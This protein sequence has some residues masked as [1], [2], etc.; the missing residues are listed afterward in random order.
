MMSVEVVGQAIRE[1]MIKYEEQKDVWV[2]KMGE[3]FNE[4][5]FHAWFTKQVL[6]HATVPNGTV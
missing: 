5:E 4:D 2:K 1:L 6:K 3:K